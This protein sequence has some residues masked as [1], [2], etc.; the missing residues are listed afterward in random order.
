MSVL[1]DPFTKGASEAIRDGANRKRSESQKGIPKA[2]KERVPTTS[3]RTSAQ[4]KASASGT[5]RGTVEREA[6]QTVSGWLVRDGQE[7]KAHN[8]ALDAREAPAGPDAACLWCRAAYA[9]RATGGRPQKFCGSGCRRACHAAARRWAVLELEA[10]R[11]TVET[12]LGR[13]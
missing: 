2:E 12:V 9:R 13:G 4:L 3:G 5:N 11:L 8:P 10:G 6:Q 1:R 7:A